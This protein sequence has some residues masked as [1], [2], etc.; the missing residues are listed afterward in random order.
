[1]HSTATAPTVFSTTDFEYAAGVFTQEASD[2]GFRAGAPM[3]LHIG[4]ENHKSA[5]R[6]EFR[7]SS[8]KHDLELDILWWDYRSTTEVYG[9]LIV[10]IVND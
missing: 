10:R 7:L 1:M 2:L 5:R 8:T 4:L 9:G 3:P 6:V